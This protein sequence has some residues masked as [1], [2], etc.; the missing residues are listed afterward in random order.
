MGAA[1]DGQEGCDRPELLGDMAEAA[2]MAPVNLVGLGVKVIRAAGLDVAEQIVDSA[3]RAMKVACGCCLAKRRR[4]LIFGP[5]AHWFS[6]P[7]VMD[8]RSGAKGSQVIS[9]ITSYRIVC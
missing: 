5:L 3:L 7:P 2:N 6:V 4:W 8:V 1:S 9:T